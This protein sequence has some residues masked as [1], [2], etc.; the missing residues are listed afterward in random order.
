M[1]MLYANPPWVPFSIF[2]FCL[3]MLFMSLALVSN[4]SPRSFLASYARDYGIRLLMTADPAVSYHE[5]RN[6]TTT[7]SLFLRPFSSEIPPHGIL[8]PD[9]TEPI[10][11][12]NVCTSLLRNDLT[13]TLCHVCD[14]TF[15]SLFAPSRCAASN[16]YVLQ[17]LN[18]GSVF[19]SSHRYHGPP[20]GYLLH[21]HHGATLLPA[22]T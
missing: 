22:T 11:E 4:H 3:Y 13:R 7:I 21:R 16:K 8:Q 20:S 5:A 2:I 14:E 12:T 18:S 9:Q 10:T 1:R 19:L 6:A 15:C 17:T